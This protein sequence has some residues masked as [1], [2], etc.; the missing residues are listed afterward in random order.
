MFV[1]IKMLKPYLIS[2]VIVLL[3]FFYQA[4]FAETEITY[5]EIETIPIETLNPQNARA[6][7]QL[8]YVLNVGDSIVA[9]INTYSKQY[10]R[11]ATLSD[12]Q[13]FIAAFLDAQTEVLI[14]MNNFSYVADTLFILNLSDHAAVAP[15]LVHRQISYF[16]NSDKDPDNPPLERDKTL[17]NDV[18]TL[19]THAG[20][21]TDFCRTIIADVDYMS[22]NLYDILLS[23][24]NQLPIETTMPINTW[25][26]AWLQWVYN[27]NPA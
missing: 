6:R 13:A 11:P 15:E 23:P 1:P 4:V 10:N 24:S 20:T 21:I 18:E 9:A 12:V 5:Q 17:G 19:T 27:D 3:S 8:N 22:M 25:C 16:S 26:P 2:P 14:D 7:L